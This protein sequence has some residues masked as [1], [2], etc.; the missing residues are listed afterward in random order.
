[1][2]LKDWG[3]ALLIVFAWDLTFVVIH[4]G[5]TGYHRYC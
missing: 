1:M 2:S 4:W 5:S 3:F